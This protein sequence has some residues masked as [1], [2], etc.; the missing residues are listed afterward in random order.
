MLSTRPK[1][2]TKQDKPTVLPG[3]NTSDGRGCE[4]CARTSPKRRL[5]AVL[6]EG[7][8]VKQRIDQTG[9]S[10]DSEKEWRNGISPVW[11]AHFAKSG[12]PFLLPSRIRL[13]N[14]H[15]ASGQVSLRWL[16]LYP[17]GGTPL[18]RGVQCRFP[19]W[20]QC[21][22]YSAPAYTRG[23]RPAC[24]SQGHLTKHS[25]LAF[26]PLFVHQGLHRDPGS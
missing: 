4:P 26:L 15:D 14:A 2:A 16:P 6:R 11:K 21:D 5:V 9:G 20:S 24:P 7:R 18:A 22:R 1:T 10:R 13:M 3:V 17:F 8:Y 12:G 25:R 23:V 19:A